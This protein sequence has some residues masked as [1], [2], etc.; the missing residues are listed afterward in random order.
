MKPLKQMPKR[1]PPLSAAQLA[2][3]KPDP[4]KVIELID[5]AVPGLRFR[6]TPAGTRSW[7]L[8]IRANGKMRRFE[9]GRN[10][11]LSE[12]RS[13]AEELKVKIKN[14]LDPTAE[15]R[16]RREKAKLA[17][18]GIGTMG[19]LV[20]RYFEH[21]PGETLKTKDDQR[22]GIRFVFST[23]LKMPTVE[24]KSAELQ[25]SVDNHKAKVSAAC[26]VAY[27]NPILR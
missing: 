16:A 12:A 25:L 2:R 9:V 3:I 23:H 19:S 4:A 20:D 11:S 8:N 26:A 24:L 21:G 13:K 22:N 1:V 27:L 15:K 6:V 7:S 5:G 14:G 17:L 18:D 10:L